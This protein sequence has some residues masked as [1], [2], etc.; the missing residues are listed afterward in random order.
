MAACGAAC[1]LAAS[2]QAATGR[3]RSIRSGQVV[4]DQGPAPAPA[5]SGQWWR[6]RPV[7]RPGCSRPPCPSPGWSPGEAP[8]D[9]AAA[10]SAGS[11]TTSSPTCSR[12]WSGKARRSSSYARVS[13]SPVPNSE[14]YWKLINLDAFD[15][16]FWLPSSM[17][18]KR[19]QSESRLGSRGPGIHGPDRQ[20]RERRADRLAAPER[21]TGAVFAP[22]PRRPPTNCWRRATGRGRTARSTSMDG[23]GDGL[24]YRVHL[25]YSPDGP[26]GPGLV[27]RRT[28]PDVRERPGSRS[29][30]GGAVEHARHRWRPTAVREFYTELPDDFPEEVQELARAVT[31]Q[32]STAFERATGA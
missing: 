12:T 31:A 21:A 5:H 18:V 13:P 26:V 17:D 24:L 23:P 22:Q 1:L 15:G 9:S 4:P 8:P 14:L 30:R 19:P 32:T 25:G 3:V 28:L 6:S 29:L 27:R 2:E 7:E 20:G 10:C 11:P 16:E